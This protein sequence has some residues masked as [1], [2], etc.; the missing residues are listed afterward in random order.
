MQLTKLTE[1]ESKN[2]TIV[3]FVAML[4][5]VLM[6]GV[7]L[8][9]Y[10]MKTSKH[11]NNIINILA[12][13]YMAVVVGAAILYF[14][15][16]NNKATIKAETEMVITPIIG[17]VI[18]IVV[19]GVVLFMK[20]KVIEKIGSTGGFYLMNESTSTIIGDATSSPMELTKTN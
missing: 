6:F 2:I 9:S 1:S 11:L 12:G 16:R 18:G 20:N 4:L 15:Y 14:V 17:I 13:L 7:L 8:F 19:S 5:V 10:L 3:G